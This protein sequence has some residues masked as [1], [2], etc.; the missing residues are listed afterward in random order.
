LRDRWLRRAVVALRRQ[1]LTLAST[2]P[3]SA[4]RG[5][6]NLRER[7]LRHRRTRPYTPRT[8]GKAERRERAARMGLQLLDSRVY[9]L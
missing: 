1:R 2:A 6:F 3:S 4:G 9:Q 8:N 7:G 5:R